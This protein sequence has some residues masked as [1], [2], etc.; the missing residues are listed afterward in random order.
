[1]LFRNDCVFAVHIRFTYRVIA[2]NIG[3]GPK[4]A[5]AGVRRKLF[6]SRGCQAVRL[7]EG[8]EFEGTEVQIWRSGGSV[9]LAPLTS[10]PS[11]VEALFRAAD[12]LREEPLM[13]E[14]GRQP[15]M[16]DSELG[17]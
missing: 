12:G 15:R 14:G 3:E 8:Y 17:E 13:P 2:P 1:M 16:P 6:T 7:P 10:D 5:N 9:F 4:M 11:D